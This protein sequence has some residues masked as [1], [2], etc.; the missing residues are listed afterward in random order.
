[1]VIIGIIL[2]FQ[3]E[4]SQNTNNQVPKIEMCRKNTPCDIEAEKFPILSLKTSIK[5]AEEKIHQIN[6]KTK[7]CYEI[8]KSSTTN[9]SECTQVRNKYQHRIDI[10]TNYQLFQ[11]D[12]VLSI[13]VTRTQKDLCT[14]IYE[15]IPYDILIYDKEHKTVITQNEFIQKLGY[16][17]EDIEQKILESLNNYSKEEFQPSIDD[18]LFDNKIKY[19]LFYNKKGECIV[20]YQIK[21]DQTFYYEEITLG[22]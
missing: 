13:A 12:T 16:T 1:M 10:K 9:S 4:K 3:K 19:N 2:C 6:Q 14:D 5:E 21:S 15:T 22:N 7:E 8:V 18:I 17:E 20:A 11:D